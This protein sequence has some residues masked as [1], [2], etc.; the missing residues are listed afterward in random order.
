M[1]NFHTQKLRGWQ[2]NH[3]APVRKSKRLAVSIASL[4]QTGHLPTDGPAK[5]RA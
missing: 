4:S 3:A 5:W 2:F 1:G